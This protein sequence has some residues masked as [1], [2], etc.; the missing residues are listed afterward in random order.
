MVGHADGLAG[1][2]LGNM[3]GAVPVFGAAALQSR[4][5]LLQQFA[6]ASGRTRLDA[7][8]QLAKISPEL[9]GRVIGADAPR[10]S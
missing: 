8:G 4:L 7:I 2:L 1:S 5:V 6:A 10:H 3:D 9:P